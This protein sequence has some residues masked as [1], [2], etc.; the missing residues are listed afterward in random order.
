MHKTGKFA[1]FSVLTICTIA[2]LA[3]LIGLY[4]PRD[5]NSELKPKQE[6]DQYFL[7]NEAK[8]GL[9]LKAANIKSNDTVM[10]VS[11]II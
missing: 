9:M 5:D 7:T 8:I 11:F 6:L 3:F 2:F 1:L 4:G 10:E